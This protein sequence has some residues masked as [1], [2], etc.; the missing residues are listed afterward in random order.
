MIRRP[1]RSTRTDTLFPYTTLF[2]S[3]F[4]PQIPYD[5]ALV[6]RKRPDD[7]FHI[8]FE[9]VILT[10]ILQPRLAGRLDP[11]RIVDAGDRRALQAIDRVR[12]PHAVEQHETALDLVLCGDPRK[13]VTPLFSAFGFVFP[14]QIVQ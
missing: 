9:L 14:A 12:V 4:V 11:A 13:L 8:G 10:R 2:R 6:V 7:V 5:D 1:P 3:G